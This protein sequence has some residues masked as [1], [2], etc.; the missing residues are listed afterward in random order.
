[1]AVLTFPIGMLVPVITK[2]V[3]STLTQVLQV[4]IGDCSA[5][6]ANF[7][8]AVDIIITYPNGQQVPVNFKMSADDVKVIAQEGSFKAGFCEIRIS[9]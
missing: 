2:A 4:K 5:V 9:E 8:I 6:Q 3:E 1:M 7:V